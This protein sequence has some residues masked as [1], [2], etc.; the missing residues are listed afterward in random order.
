MGAIS[1]ARGYRTPGDKSKSAPEEQAGYF[2]G[3][4]GW[5]R[6]AARAGLQQLL[7]R[8]ERARFFA[9]RPIAES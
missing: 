8:K 3:A 6:M 9:P 2:T 4:L 5:R 1:P 7:N